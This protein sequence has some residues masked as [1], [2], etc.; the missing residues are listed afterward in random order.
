MDSRED[1]STTLIDEL[2]LDPVEARVLGCLVEK[3]AITPEVYPLTL[4]ATVAACNQK[5]NRDPILDLEPGEVGNALRRLEGKGVVAGSLGARSSRYEHR[6]DTIY[7]VTPRQ[8]AVLA[9]L[10]LRG[11]QTMNEISTHSAR[12]AQFPGPDDLRGA[13]DRLM[14]HA[15]PLAVRLPHGAG[16]REDRY[17]H[18][19]AGPVQA[20]QFAT[21]AKST[22]RS[23]DE[24]DLLDR[25]SR[26]E[27]LV[28]TLKGE[29]AEI[30]ARLSHD[31]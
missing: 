23:R 17:M 14:H 9:A 11:P 5:T 27:N 26:L 12:L 22:P 15:P 21:A 16:Q 30:V 25:I 24:S 28:A 8:R 31:E 29:V 4:N 18:L 2:I 13:V 10:L 3:Q 7:G 19:L 20:E 1:A 6:M